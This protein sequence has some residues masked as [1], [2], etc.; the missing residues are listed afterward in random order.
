VELVSIVIPSYQARRWL[1]GAIESA[2]AQ[3]WP[4]CEVIVAD[5]GSTD[6]TAAVA[7]SFGQRVRLVTGPNVGPGGARN[8]GLAEAKGDWVQFLDADD[9]LLPRKVER[10]L[11]AARR[12]DEIP[13]ARLLPFDGPPDGRLARWLRGAPAPFRPEEPVVTA[14]TYEIQTSQPLYPARWLRDVEGFRAGMRWLEDIDL[15]LRLALQ[16]ARFVPIDEPLVLLRDHRDPGRQRLH[17]GA[18]LGRIQG[19]QKM[20]AAIHEA[21]EMSPAVASALAD[22]LAYAARQAWLAGEHTAASAAYLRA[23]TLSPAARPTRIPFYNA[24][25][26]RLGLSHTERLLASLAR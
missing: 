12:P 1:A 17:P 5:D 8:R 9:V 19:E 23:R 14:L 15:N 24:V 3:T 11:A 21:G 2:L 7:R 18:A 13:F 26:R 10:C 20:L 6:G 25:V 16:G 4:R 22:R